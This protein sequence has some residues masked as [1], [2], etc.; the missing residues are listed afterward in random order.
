VFS[1]IEIRTHR[2]FEQGIR[3]SLARS[4][5]ADAATILDVRRRGWRLGRRAAAN[6]SLLF[7]KKQV[8]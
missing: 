3:D 7:L 4:A 6:N 8:Y 1:S 2:Q 5:L